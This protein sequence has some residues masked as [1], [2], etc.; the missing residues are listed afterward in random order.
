[1]NRFKLSNN[2]CILINK[3]L[4]MFPSPF[5]KSILKYYYVYNGSHIHVLYLS[6]YSRIYKVSEER[7]CLFHNI[8]VNII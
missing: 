6:L 8:Y 5:N 2:I 1:M 3:Y 7:N 4:L